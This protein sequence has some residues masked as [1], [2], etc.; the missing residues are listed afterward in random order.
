MASCT[1]TP[2]TP[3][4]RTAITSIERSWLDAGR[5]IDVRSASPGDDKHLAGTFE[6]GG[7]VELAE[8]F[9]DLLP[10]LLTAGVI[11]AGQHLVQRAE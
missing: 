4:P 7:A 8:L 5:I 9:G 10:R 3:F 6:A 2:T 1:R 11:E